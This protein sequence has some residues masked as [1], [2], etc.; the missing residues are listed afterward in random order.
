MTEIK[1]GTEFSVDAAADKIV[2][3]AMSAAAFPP[4][5][6]DER[7]RLRYEIQDAVDALIDECRA[8]YRE[9]R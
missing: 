9:Q 1:A 3:L 2:D 7:D 5:S 8:Y 6:H 4:L